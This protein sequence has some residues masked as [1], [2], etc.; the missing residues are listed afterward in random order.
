MLT[1]KEQAHMY[2]MVKEIYHHSGIDGIR[3]VSFETIQKEAERKV[4]AW[5]AKQLKKENECKALMIE[6]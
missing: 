2:Q 6:K 3:P 1:D 5:K 4:L